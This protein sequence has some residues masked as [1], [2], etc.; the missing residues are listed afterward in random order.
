MHI[1]S[2]VASATFLAASFG[3]QSA[4]QQPIEEVFPGKIC[5]IEL[6]FSYSAST[7]LISNIGDPSPEAELLLSK[8]IAIAGIE[9]RIEIYAADIERYATAFATN[10]WGKKIVVY[11][12]SHRGWANGGGPTISDVRTFAHEIGHHVGSHV[13]RINYSRHEQELEADRFAGYVM[14]RMGFS[15]E[16]STRRFWDYPGTKYHPG[17]LRRKAAV[18]NGWIMAAQLL[19]EERGQ[20]EMRFQSEPSDIDGTPCRIV[21]VC[22]EDGAEQRLSCQDYDGLW[23]WK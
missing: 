19:K 5:A 12:R 21:Q 18:T 16:Q 3:A 4:A 17:G 10:R 6:G 20:C 8:I 22:S 2:V 11:D 15:L 9:P 13:H 14:A 23:Y 7:G 1:R